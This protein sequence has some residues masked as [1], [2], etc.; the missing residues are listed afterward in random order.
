MGRDRG[1]PSQGLNLLKKIND[2]VP[3]GGIS[4]ICYIWNQS[5]VSVLLRDAG[6]IDHGVEGVGT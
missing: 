1:I 4:I 5:L 2:V 3:F 6:E